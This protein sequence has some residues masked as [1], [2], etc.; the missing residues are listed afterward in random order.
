MF[1]LWSELRKK[2]QP[3]RAG[4]TLLELLLV[5]AII[6]IL[7]GLLLPGI[8]RARERATAIG[9]LNNLK[10]LQLAFH[11]YANDQNDR[12]S[13]AETDAG[14]P[15][16][17]RWVNGAMVWWSFAEITNR[18]LLLEP[19]P[20]HLGPY[21]QAAEVFHCPGDR[22]RSNLFRARGALRARSY[23]MNNYV[24]LGDGL[25]IATDGTFVYSPTAF[26]KWAD[27]NRTSP[28]GIFVF[29]DEHEATIGNGAFSFYWRGTP[30]N[31]WWNGHWPA[32][33]H[34]RQ[35]VFSFA[36]GHGELHKWRDP[37]TTP[38][39]TSQDEVTTEKMNATGNPDYAWVWERANGGVSYE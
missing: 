11:L 28:S 5:V 4:F 26:L 35:G 21:L 14:V 32:G 38:R 18:Q 36:D 1:R 23:T 7:A 37:R 13:P 24:V 16:Y 3:A 31:G 33:R 30:P 27:F 6:A 12:L 17:P 29:L 2:G 19:G 34:G 8:S 15:S 39:I 9:C 10:Q 20:G 22:S 25:S